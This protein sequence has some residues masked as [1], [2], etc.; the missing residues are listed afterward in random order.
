MPTQRQIFEALADR[1]EPV[2]RQ[3]FMEAIAEIRSD[4]TMALVVDALRAGN[5]QAALDA[6]NIERAAFG[7]FEMALL[8]AYNEGGIAQ[9]NLMRLRDP[10]GNAVRFRFGVR[11]LGAEDWISRY[12]ASRVDGFTAETL[13]AA[14]ATLQEGLERGQNPVETA[15]DL[16]GRK[17]RAT[18]Q[19]VGGIIGLTDDQ[20]S[21]VR[22]VRKALDENDADALMRFIGM[23]QRQI[24][25]PRRDV[26]ASLKGKG[27]TL[28][29]RRFDSAIIDV[30]EGKTRRVSQ[31][32]ARKI[33]TALNDRT[34]NYRARRIS[35]TETLNALGKARDDAMRQAIEQGKV[36]PR[37]VTKIW[38]HS[39]AEHPRFQHQA[40]SGKSVG[41]FEPFVMADGTRLRYP[42]DP[43]APASHT[44][45]CRCRVEYKISYARML[46]EQRRVA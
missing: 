31:D 35:Q 20:A 38:R 15:R 37:F 9:A 34:L 25:K 42:H 13:A 29:D 14:R 39:F 26:L 46:A 44:V 17:S 33:I 23:G 2:L 19:R 3:H 11:D 32:G 18:G 28:R 45:F 10:D 36:D 27:L 6:L 12:A 1:L 16:V 30:I 8:Q 41:Y 40:M 4:V 24:G 22:W 5:V 21:T 43:D 7:R